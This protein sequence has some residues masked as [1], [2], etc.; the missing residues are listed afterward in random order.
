MVKIINPN[1]L[2]DEDKSL[3]VRY[4]NENPGVHFFEKN[5][6]YSIDA[7]PETIQFTHQLIKTPSQDTQNGDLTFLIIGKGNEGT[8]GKG[9][10]SRV[11]DVIGGIN[12][13]ASGIVTQQDITDKAV[14]VENITMD[15]DYSENHAAKKYK[16]SK[17]SS[18][19]PEKP[20][21][22]T[23]KSSKKSPESFRKY[24][25][26][27]NKLEGVT[28]DQ[29]ALA[30]LQEDGKQKLDAL[31]D[32]LLIP[33]MEAYQTQVSNKNIVHRDIKPENI[34]ANQDSINIIDFDMRK[35]ISGKSD[36]P[37]GT[38]GY[39]PPELFRKK[40]FGVDD[41]ANKA[42]LDTKRDVF[43][44]GMIFT[45]TINPDLSVDNFLFQIAGHLDE[46]IE[47]AETLNALVN[48]NNSYNIQSVI[49]KLSENVDRL[50]QNETDEEQLE[51]LNDIKGSMERG[52]YGYLNDDIEAMDVTKSAAHT[53][54]IEL[55]QMM[56][57]ADR[58]QRPSP[59]DILDKLHEI[60]RQLKIEQTHGFIDTESE[61][62]DEDKSLSDDE[63]SS[64]AAL[65]KALEVKETGLKN[66]PEDDKSATNTATSQTKPD[67]AQPLDHQEQKNPTP[68]K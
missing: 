51:I 16:K 52:F 12:I 17:D 8:L 50:I 33:L 49:A 63:H 20:I 65:F 56:T 32:S 48:E 11:R 55:I 66:R 61:G 28:I 53:Q 38:I 59:A 36:S 43:A 34:M 60:S 39:I 19:A 23:I 21:E 24:V 54:F 10:F 42:I 31:I 47:R 13:S 35:K 37:E 18:S 7:S 45:S 1:S 6:N 46:D 25:S 22:R 30:M 29:A 9:G 3:L 27:I 5:K 15:P 14:R 68:H 67:T 44:L 26:V 62:S 58:K 40:K 64:T 57:S 4:L 2:T 41:S